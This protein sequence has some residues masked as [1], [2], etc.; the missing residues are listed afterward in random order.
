MISNQEN[1]LSFIR[2]IGSPSDDSLNEANQKIKNFPQ[3]AEIFA[4]RSPKFVEIFSQLQ[5]GVTSNSISIKFYQIISS[6]FESLIPKYNIFFRNLNYLADLLITRHLNFLIELM[7]M[8]RS[9]ISLHIL[10]Q[11]ASVHST[12]CRALFS[13]LSKIAFS[14]SDFRKFIRNDD[15]EDYV[16]LATIFLNNNEVALQFLSTKY[17][18]SP[19]WQ[20]LKDV[21][22]SVDSGFI[23]ALSKASK[24]L[25][26][27]TKSWVFNDMTLKSLSEFPLNHNNEASAPHLMFQLLESIMEGEKSIIIEDPQRTYCFQ[28]HDLDPNPRNNHILKF[29]RDLDVWKKPSHRELCLFIFK[30]SPDLVARFLIDQHRGIS[31]SL[32]LSTVSTLLFIGRVIEQEWPDFLNDIDFFNEGR[33]LDYLFESILPSVLTNVVIDKFLQSQSI[34]LRSN[35]IKI[36]LKSVNKFLKLPQFMKKQDLYT[37]FRGRI[38]NDL[39]KNIFNA[40]FSDADSIFPYSLKLLI[41]LDQ[42]FPFY[43]SDSINKELSFIGK[44]QSYSPLSQLLILQLIPHLQKPLLQIKNLCSLLANESENV[45]PSQIKKAIHSA[46]YAIIKEA[47]VFNGFENEIPIFI[48]ESIRLD[49]GNELFELINLVKGSYFKYIGDETSSPVCNALLIQK[50]NKLKAG[51]NSNSKGLNPLLKCVDL[52]S[53]MNG[54]EPNA[55]S[56]EIDL[57]PAVIMGSLKWYALE[58]SAILLCASVANQVTDLDLTLNCLIIV[59]SCDPGRTLQY[60]MN[61]PFI[62]S[63]AFRGSETFDSFMGQLIEWNKGCD[64]T[65][66]QL[67]LD[68]NVKPSVI[69]QVV[70]FIPEKFNKELLKKLIKNKLSIRPVIIENREEVIAGYYGMIDTLSPFWKW[71]FKGFQPLNLA[72]ISKRVIHKILKNKED[73]NHLLLDLLRT[74]YITK[75]FSLVEMIAMT[76]DDLFSFNPEKRDSRLFVFAIEI[77]PGCKNV[78]VNDS[79]PVC[80]LTESALDDPLSIF[81]KTKKEWSYEFLLN[82]IKRSDFQREVYDEVLLNSEQGENKVK[83]VINFYLNEQNESILKTFEKVMMEYIIAHPETVGK[84]PKIESEFFDQIATEIMRPPVLIEFQEDQFEGIANVLIGTTTAYNSPTMVKIPLRVILYLATGLSTC[85]SFYQLLEHAHVSPSSFLFATGEVAKVVIQQLDSNLK[86]YP[87]ALCRNSSY[88]APFHIVRQGGTVFEV[89][90]PFFRFLLHFAWYLLSTSAVQLENYIDSGAV[91]IIFRALSSKFQHSREIAYAS[92]SE[93]Y[94]L[95]VKKTDYK[96]HDQL[97]LLLETLINAV[98]E[99]GMRFTSLITYFLTLASSIIIKPSHSIFMNLIQFL[100]SDKTLRVG[101]VP[102]FNNLFGQNG[103]DFRNQRNWILMMLKNGVCET[104]DVELMKKGKI[105]ERLCAFFASPLSEKKSR[106]MILDILI[107]A[108]KYAKLEGVMIWTYSLMTEH[109]ARPHIDQIVT[110]ALSI[111]SK[112]EIEKDCLYAIVEIAWSNFQDKLIDS[113]DRVV[114]LLSILLQIN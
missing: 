105:I 61:H 20:V 80:F 26:Q 83:Y 82:Q 107:N 28:P 54:N 55:N 76:P 47:D 46:L 41:V 101:T 25:N 27:S 24:E 72:K 53:L 59:V 44:F 64:E 49:K 89:D 103:L 33:S 96:F 32:D 37:K 13:S 56:Q 71:A 18:L 70:P 6:I 12:H 85:P 93:L 92:L 111:R 19:I 9:R 34:V 51:S 5:P 65:L 108:S 75:D 38:P 40:K 2:L 104:S 87:S 17:S 35:I 7:T 68:G 8:Q 22:F 15:P 112:D 90:T 4:Q 30:Q 57:S 42:I 84:P 29:L 48:G 97:Q 14:N 3:I 99:P 79:L 95:N 69:E 21:D 36:L 43:V 98:T 102:L 39:P 91:S 113:R 67:F 77:F 62:K 1:F 45:I 10:V 114:K 81:E 58:T 110:L 88:L 74:I 106:D 94:D 73:E 78:R 86:I 63:S 31:A 11:I 52:I 60:V 100:A 16:K 50:E 109:F 66:A 23:I